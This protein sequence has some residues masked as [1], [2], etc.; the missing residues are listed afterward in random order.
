M[1][2]AFLL[3]I[4]VALALTS[5]GV[6]GEAQVRHGREIVVTPGV[7]YIIL[8]ATHP[9]FAGIMTSITAR[10]TTLRPGNL[11]GYFSIYSAILLTFHMYI[12]P[13]R[14]YRGTIAIIPFSSNFCKILS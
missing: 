2:R 6:K 4:A 5:A 14:N 10:Y 8:D 13:I 3:S 7:R 1:F 9:A 11:V 12:I